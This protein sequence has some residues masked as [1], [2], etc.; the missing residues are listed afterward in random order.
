MGKAKVNGLRGIDLGVADLSRARDFYIGTWQLTPVAETRDGVLLRGTGP[1]HH[2]LGLYRHPT[3]AVLR[4]DLTAADRGVVDA[5]HDGLTGAAA[6]TPPAAIGEPGGGY[7]FSFRDPDGRNLRIV[8]EASRHADAAPPADRP[9]KI[10]H[11]VLNAPDPVATVDFYCRRLGFR[12]IDQTKMLTFLNCN[13]D[14][15][16]IAFAKSDTAMLHHIA[17]E[18]P[19]IDSV[20]RGA[21]R[22]RDAGFPLEWGIGRHGPGNN[23]FSYFLSPDGMVVEYTTEVQQVDADY[24]VKGPEGWTWPPGRNDQWGIGI[25]PTHR[26]EEAH[27]A[28]GFA[29]EPFVPA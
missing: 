6:L 11:L 3:T 1:H 24:L 2:I 4:V 8:A 12:I 19:D 18:M 28:V 17:F 5:L 15:H 9:T 16:T 25:G 22:L 26:M 21:G 10:S 14:H 23:V 7:G 13:D 29:A 27:T 20:M